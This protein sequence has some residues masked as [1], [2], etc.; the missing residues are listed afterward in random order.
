MQKNSEFWDSVA[1]EYDSYYASEWSRLENSL[2]RRWLQGVS[3]GRVLDLGCG[4]GFAA[5]CVHTDKTEL[6]GVDVSKSMI[7]I[8]AA[9][10]VY[11]ELFIADLNEDLPEFGGSFDYV[12]STWGALSYLNDPLR[13]L[14]KVFPILRSAG[15]LKFMT[16]NKYALRRLARL[17][18]SPQE[19]Y[20]TRGATNDG[21]IISLPEIKEWEAEAFRVGFTSVDFQTFG[22]FSGLMEKPKFWTLDNA[23][24]S[25]F[26]VGHMALM[27]VKK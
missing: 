4:T 20:G 19:R 1:E 27:T 9:K 21:G 8:V 2:V 3:V 24:T 15:T 5:T 13:V 18:F 11:K 25:R 7:E 12:I 23:I 6:L 26:H 16:F 17:K 14:G 10:G 22:A